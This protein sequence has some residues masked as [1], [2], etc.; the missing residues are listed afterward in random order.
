M[1][2][3]K[4]LFVLFFIFLFASS[5]H[6]Q[7]GESKTGAWYQYIWS[8]GLTDNGWGINGDFQY[9][10]YEGIGD[11]QQ[12]IARAAV[13]YN[14][15]DTPLTVVGGYGYFSSGAFGE[16][17]ITSYEHR[18]HQ[19]ALLSQ[20][21]G[22]RLYLGHRIR[23]EERFVE[24]QDFRTRFRYMLAARI[25]FNQT[26]LSKNAFYAVAWSE[27]FANGQKDIGD[28]RTVPLFDR[29]WSL[30]GLGYSI[31]DTMKFELGYMRE[32]TE[33]WTKGQLVLH[34]NHTW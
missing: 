28:G 27:I 22:N 31:N 20:K 29:N 14:F 4:L 18:L 34:L 1:G 32:T 13:T 8:K 9:R 24:G 23:L 2:K 33:T 5:T 3:I 26:T 12:F 7:E 16:S 25:P 17:D 11:F 15:K 6:G 30:I 21:I 19:D 10:D